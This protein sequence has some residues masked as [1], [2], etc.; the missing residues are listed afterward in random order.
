MKPV[1]M[2]SIAWIT[3]AVCCLFTAASPDQAVLARGDS[4]YHFGFKRSQN[5]QPASIDQEGFKEI[6]QKN[7]G[8]FLGDPADKSL[9]LTFDNG[10]E[11]GLTP[12]ILDVLKAKKVPAAFFVTGHYLLDQPDLVKRM[13]AEGHVIGNHSWSHPDM[14]TIGDDQLR[15]ELAKVR[16]ETTRLTGKDRMHFLRP[17]RGIF[18]ARTLALAQKEGY[19]SIFWSVAYKDWVTDS[20]RGAAYAYEKVVSQLH[21]GAIILLHAVSR[22]NAAALSAIIDQARKE[23]FVFRS[24]EEL[25]GLGLPPS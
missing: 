6:L 4:P 12:Q 23:G 3:I 13:A 9:Y 21:P 15:V 16:A 14:T 7:G 22:D 17:P 20:Q 19:T 11:N 18:D 8:V 1:G 24:L 10:Y 25:P 5:R 2:L